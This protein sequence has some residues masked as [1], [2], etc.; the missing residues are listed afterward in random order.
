MR[1]DQISASQC[2][3]I[4]YDVDCGILMPESV[5]V[6]GCW[7]NVILFSGARME[8]IQLKNQKPGVAL[9]GRT[10]GLLVRSGH[11]TRVRHRL[12]S[13]ESLNFYWITDAGRL[14]AKTVNQN[15]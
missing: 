14:A 8:T 10:G 3:R 9:Y 11:A 13:T 12:D 5:P 7:E 1:L 6:N 4:L 2:L 15:T